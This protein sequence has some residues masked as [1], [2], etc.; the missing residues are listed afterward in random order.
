MD[1][2]LA[3]EFFFQ[4]G[5]FSARYASHVG[6]SSMISPWGPSHWED[7]RPKGAILHY[8]ADEDFHRVLRW[9]AR[10][11]YQ[12]KVSANVV[13]ADGRVAAHEECAWGL[14][15]IRDLPAT[16]V[17]CRR[18]ETPSWHAT[19][20]NKRCYG[21]E[22]VN[23]GELREHGGE[24]VTWR[25]RDKS[26]SDWTA[27]W[28][29]RVKKTPIF[30][31]GRW[32][33]PYNPAAIEAAVS[34]LRYVHAKFDESLAPSLILGHEAVQGVDTR[35]IHTD[36]RDPGPSFPI[37]GIRQSVLE[38]S[39]DICRYLWFQNFKDDELNGITWRGEA[40]QAWARTLG[41]DVDPTLWVACKRWRMRVEAWSSSLDAFWP[42]GRYALHLLGYYVD[43][44]RTSDMG[45]T[46]EEQQSVRIFQTMAGLTIDGIPG[47]ATRRALV[48]RL[49][50][51]GIVE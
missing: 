16:V 24:F 31:Y 45:A 5:I 20:V 23:A 1:A 33:A 19:W 27:L 3:R 41:A 49:K 15:L 11:K 40:I 32:W 42:V 36:K 35:G 8:T 6:L 28:N 17:Q 44:T 30:Q 46:S 2:S 38:G 34:V 18:P 25:K 48:S 37:H 12:A 51:R 13:I 4:L 39:T 22:L 29:P 26:A 14:S 50:D 21:V 43:L 10:P 7:G 47:P 9:F